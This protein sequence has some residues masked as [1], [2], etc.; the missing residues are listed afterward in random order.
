M[1]LLEKLVVAEVSRICGI[2]FETLLPS[3]PAVLRLSNPVNI[4]REM[5]RDLDAADYLVTMKCDGTRVVYV[6]LTAW[7]CTYH[8]KL[9]RKCKFTL[10]SERAAEATECEGLHYVLDC[11]EMPN[12]KLI[13]HDVLLF[14]DVPVL[15]RPFVQRLKYLYKLREYPTM[16]Q[17]K[18]FQPLEQLSTIKIDEGDC[19]GLIFLALQGTFTPGLSQDILKWK[20]IEKISIDM[21]VTKKGAMVRNEG[22]LVAFDA[23]TGLDEV[24]RGLI[25]E[26]FFDSSRSLWFPGH[27]RE[28]KSQPNS[29]YVAQQT[30][31]CVTE[32]EA[33]T[34][35]EL[36]MAIEAR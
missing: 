12:A 31:L 32:A 15:F 10:V 14:E 18:R 36:I 7:G 8:V 28:D 33:I 1:F 27:V 29:L 9:D 34:L 30:A 3:R 11:E 5:L 4:T 24:Q 25:Y 22:T 13:C 2:D 26:F 21:L 16:P 19:D 35:N 20:P 23:V 17:P 6:V